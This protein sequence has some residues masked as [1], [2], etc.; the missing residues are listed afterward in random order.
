MRQKN[1]FWACTQELI[2]IYNKNN[3]QMISIKSKSCIF[4]FP[5]LLGRVFVFEDGFC[6]CLC[7]G[8][9][10]VCVCVCVCVLCMQR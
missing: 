5:F 7:V 4:N 6:V 3:E 8:F 10:C 1:V 2:E 9:V